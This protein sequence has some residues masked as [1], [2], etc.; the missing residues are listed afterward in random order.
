MSMGISSFNGLSVPADSTVDVWSLFGT[1]AIRIRLHAFELTA[2]DI[3]AELVT[4]ILRRA[5]TVGSVGSDPGTEEKLDEGSAAL[6]ATLRT[7]D[8]TEATGGGD[9]MGFQWEKLGPIGHVFTPEMRPISLVS[10]G[11][12]LTWRTATAAVVSGYVAWEEV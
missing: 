4:F 7:L 2:D 5:T 9:I 3:A 10:E 12:A 1:S 8:T 6:L 11:F